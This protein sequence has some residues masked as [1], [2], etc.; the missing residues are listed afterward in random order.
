VVCNSPPEK[1]VRTGGGKW[2]G[3]ASESIVRI[4][5]KISLRSFVHMLV[6]VCV[7]V[8]LAVVF[9]FGQFVTETIVDNNLVT[10]LAAIA[11]ASG[12]FLA[13]SLAFG[14]F[15]SQY[16]TDWLYRSHE[17]LISQ[18][19]KLADRMEKSAKK[20]PDISRSLVGRYL[21]MAFYWPG[22]PVNT[23]EVFESNKVFI[24]WVRE[25]QKKGGKKVD[26]GNIDDYE[27]FAKHAID[28]MLVENESSH[29]LI[30]LSLV[31]RYGRTLGA[32]PPLITTWTLILV[33]SL[34][35]A[36]LG[37]LNIMCDYMNLSI[38]IVPIYLCFIAGSTI[39]ID[40]WAWIQYMRMREKGWEMGVSDLMQQYGSEK[41]E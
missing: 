37:S 2:L 40:F 19:E 5:D 4:L 1:S 9:Y 39:V 24:N 26:F 6:H 3:G 27:T 15:K 17:R 20:Y 11:A 21:S 32:V 12:V 14:T 18:R 7:A 23:D 36:V 28:A 22:Q 34:I 35:F 41:H 16:Y 10:I 25:Q 33:Y 38:L 30:E 8:V 13:V 31:E 29:I